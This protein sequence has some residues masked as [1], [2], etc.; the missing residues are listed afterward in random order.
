MPAKI[1]PSQRRFLAAACARQDAGDTPEIIAYSLMWGGT[2]S[3]AFAVGEEIFN[4]S[5]GRALEDMKLIEGVRPNGPGTNVEK[6]VING[7]VSHHYR[8]RPT[9]AGREAIRKGGKP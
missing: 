1:T 3:R 6:A 9:A 5:I 2:R 7:A 8:Y 4:A